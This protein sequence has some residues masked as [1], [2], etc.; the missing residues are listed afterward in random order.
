MLK[1]TANPVISKLGKV[2]FIRLNE[3]VTWVAF[4]EERSADQDRARDA[5]ENVALQCLIDTCREEVASNPTFAEFPGN[6]PTQPIESLIDRLTA[7]RPPHPPAA[8]VL[9]A[10]ARKTDQDRVLRNDQYAVALHQILEAARSGPLK[11]WGRRSLRADANVDEI[12]LTFLRGDNLA[13]DTSGKHIGRVRTNFQPT[14]HR[15]IIAPT[16]ELSDCYWNVELDREPFE[17]FV[18]IRLIDTDA[19]V[20]PNPTAAEIIKWYVE[21]YL[22][23]L[24]LSG[25]V[26]TESEDVAAVGQ[27]FPANVKSR[28]LVRMLRRECRPDEM[29]RSPGRP[30]KMRPE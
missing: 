16:G 3:A 18:A 24:K 11:L 22:P 30:K 14:L 21:H 23:R 15:A 27:R 1:R 6:L 20:P 28:A 26:T 5:Q 29:K 2:S 7:A 25:N 12:P 9:L 17:K 10:L 19:R 4:G 13:A 8:N